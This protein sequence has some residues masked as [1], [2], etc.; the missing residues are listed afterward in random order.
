MVVDDPPLDEEPFVSIVLPVYNERSVIDRLLEA[1][2]SI[3]YTNYEVI[4]IDDSTDPQMLE[5]LIRWKGHPRVKVLHRE[6]R[7]GYKGGALN[8]GL[9]IADPKCS[10]VLVFDAD[11]VPPKDIIQ[12]ML[13]DF[14]GEEIAAVQGYQWHM[15][16]ANE[17]WI[18][19]AIRVLFSFSNLVELVA[20]SRLR[21]FLQ[22][23]GSVMMIRKK[24]LEE[25]GG[26][27]AS[28]TEDW[29]LTLRL[30]LHGYKIVYD[31]NIKALAECPSRVKYFMKQQMRWAEGHTRDFV[32][33]AFRILRSQHLSRLQKV[34]FMFVGLVYV[35]AILFLIGNLNLILVF[36]TSS[37][38]LDVFLSYFGLF[39]LAYAGLTLPFAMTVALRLENSCREIFW[40]PY[41]L[42]LCYLAV[43]FVAFATLRGL[44]FKRGNWIRT[45]KT[46]R[47]T[48]RQRLESF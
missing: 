29:E 21:S 44:L 40:V 14:T 43:P 19:K 25:L 7:D 10:Y 26:F 37:M 16:N 18:S 1:C 11:F 31:E 8:K 45:P 39:Y 17:N 13:G 15:L 32:Q 30:Y 12:R 46:G 35:Q 27:A 34:D 20:R 48:L 6:G 3:D 33:N 38:A 22:L 2:T 42:A 23:T 9:S 47:I 36:F 4:V 5:K 24:V 28:M 41:A